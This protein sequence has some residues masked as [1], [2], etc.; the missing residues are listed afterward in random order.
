MA[1]NSSELEKIIERISKG[2]GSVSESESGGLVFEFVERA[3]DGGLVYEASDVAPVAPENSL[4][5]SNAPELVVPDVFSVE[6]KFNTPATSDYADRIRTTYV[7]Q[8]TEASENYRMKDD[9]RPRRVSPELTE[10]TRV[11]VVEAPVAAEPAPVSGDSVDPTAELDTPVEGAVLVTTTPGVAE[12]DSTETLNVFKFGEPTPVPAPKERTVEDERAEITRLFLGNKPQQVAAEQPEATATEQTKAHEPSPA[13]RRAE[14]YRIPDPVD[15]S[16]NIVDFTRRPTADMP[17]VDPEGVTDMT[18]EETKKR[19]TP[20]FTNKKQRDG[21]KDRFLDTLMSIRIRIVAAVVFGALLLGIEVMNG[22]GIVPGILS[23]FTVVPW[24]YAVFDLILVI[25]AFSLALPEAGAAMK[26]M[27]RGKPTP[28]LILPLGLVCCALYTLA[29]VITAPKSYS[30]FGFIYAVSV[31][32]VVFATYSKNRAD[33]ECFK[34]ITKNEEKRILDKK[35]T[36]TLPAENMALDGLVDEYKSRTAR[37]FRTSFVSDFFGRTGKAPE[38][39]RHTSLLLA[40]SLTSALVIGVLSYF[41]H[42]VGAYPI[43]SA[44]SA[45]SLVLFI[46]YPAFSILSHKL[47][48]MLAQKNAIAE[49]SAVVGERALYDFADVDVIAFDD[50]EIFGPDDVNLKRFIFYGDQKDV[51]VT[52]EDMCSLFSVASGPL[53]YIFTGALD[54]RVRHRPAKNPVIED[55]GISGEVNG[56]KICA[57]TEEYMHRHGIALTDTAGGS[58]GIDTT[59]LM[60]AAKDGEVYAKFF[61]RYSFSEEFTQLLPTLKER[62][63]VPLIYTRDPNVSNELLSALTA[64]ADC[65]R[66]MKRHAPDFDEDK[67]Y[68][69]ISAGVVTYGDK[70][71]AI[72]VI[73]IS[74]RFRR[75]YHQISTLEV[76]ATAVGAGLAAALSLLGITGVPTV[77][78]GLWQIAWCVFLR[79]YSSGAFPA[80]DKN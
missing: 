11:Q 65:M 27:L 21:F 25:C 63:I 33:F 15:A 6:D 76:Y 75:F 77:V 62:G 50:T 60:Y 10:V 59:K 30:L 79:I 73:L 23:A 80:P 34:M 8:F 28:E 69:S 58:G 39:P 56:H 66:V 26:R 48:Y 43:V 41:L 68:R 72:N 55:D 67:L 40:I 44:A 47:P 52:M 36:R 74:K 17:S 22:F 78:F 32:S 70:I 54:A 35:L 20:E 3:E 37:I 64:G 46:S 14:D 13:P 45:F 71:N 16:I 31:F 2:S 49:D 29:V 24:A 61:I 38:A 9:P 18:A 7:P 57:G 1:N 53:N 4:P 19:R 12:D 51:D 42:P 5:E